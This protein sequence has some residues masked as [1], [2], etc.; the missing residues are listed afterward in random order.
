MTTAPTSTPILISTRR[1][2]AT[3]P[4]EQLFAETARLRREA[5]WRKARWIPDAAAAV[6]AAVWTAIHDGVT[7]D[8]DL[9][10]VARYAAV[11][12]RRYEMRQRR[13]QPAYALE[14]NDPAD[15]AIEMVDAQRQLRQLLDRVP[16]P[17]PDVVSW[18]D[19]KSGWTAGDRLP[20][21]VKMAGARWVAR[22]RTQLE[23]GDEVA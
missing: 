9:W 22:A 3:S 17:S 7:D 12:Q 21:R 13:R 16:S 8:R 4:E 20:S 10:D 5:V 14:S 23:A 19:R 2:R 1:R 18:A 11:A 15:R 6:D